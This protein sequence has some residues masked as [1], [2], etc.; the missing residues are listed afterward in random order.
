[1]SIEPLTT[2]LIGRDAL[3]GRLTNL[4]QRAVHGDRTAT[5]LAGPAG[6]GKTSLLRAVA[7]D[8]ARQGMI[9]GWG[10]CVASGAPG[11][12]P[13]SQALNE[14]I[15]ELGVDPARALAG[16]EESLIASVATTLAATRREPDRDTGDARSARLQLMDAVSRWLGALAEERPVM[17]IM[18]DLQWA[19]GSTV[20]LLDFVAAAPGRAAVALLGAYRDDELTSEGRKRLSTLVAH[21]EHLR[22]PGL[23]PTSIEALVERTAG[24]SVPA[25]VSLAIS[26]RSAGHPLFARELATSWLS[27]ADT[28]AVPLA[29]RGLIERR[30]HGLRE[31]TADVLAV[32][33]VAGRDVASEL[34]A[35]ATDRT[36]VDV[37]LAARE[38]AD[39]GILTPDGSG[40]LRFAHDLYRET[41][42]E[43]LLPFRRQAIHSALGRVLEQRSAA[44]EPAEIARH[45]VASM[46]VDG[47]ERAVRW[48]LVAASADIDALAFTEA[49]DRLH[50][51]RS[52][53]A[54]LGLAVPPDQLVRL[55]LTEADALARAGRAP[56]ARP[57]LRL[58]RASV[59]TSG[60]AVRLA[61]VALAASQLGSQFSA[62]RDE[63]VDDLES[64]LGRPDVLP[65]AIRARLMATL[66][67]ELQHSVSA[68]RERAA[69]LSERALEIGRESGDPSAMLSCL[70]ARHDVLWT[71]GKAGERADLAREIGTVA[72]RARDAESQ[73]TGL[74]LLANAELERGSGAYLTALESCLQLLERLG[75]PRHHYT[76]VTRRA[77]LA[78]LRGDL[79]EAARGITAGEQLG[80]RIHE[81]DTGNVAMSQ[82]LELVRARRIPAQLQDFATE[83]L[84]HWVGAPVHANAVAAG[85]YARSG[86]LERAAQHTSTVLDLGS[87]QADRSYLWSV[88]VRE[89]SRAAIALGD[90]DLCRRL[91]SDLEPLAGQCG[92]NGAVVAFAGSHA[93]TA[94]LLART[95]GDLEATE[96]HLDQARL[97]YRRLGARSWLA[98]LERDAG[99]SQRP[100]QTDGRLRR[101]GSLWDIGFAGREAMVAGTKGLEDIARLVARPGVDI[102]ALELMTGTDTHR[103][104]SSAMILDRAALRSYR[105]RLAE[106]DAELDD[107]EQAHDAATVARLGGEREA[108]VDEL[109]AATTERG[110]PR[111]FA[112]YPSERARKAVSGRVRAAIAGLRPGL[113]ELAEHL[114]SS[115][116]TGTYCRYRPTDVTWHVSRD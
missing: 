52:A 24:D 70:L 97:T 11:F 67:R 50:R 41:V 43:A 81:P 88:L 66:A 87:W 55:I 30:L 19:D 35:S 20:E 36:A 116:I 34:V 1:M 21:S 56:E 71:P 107:A 23:D 25:E 114:D 27:T 48:S 90:L 6:I 72:H 108:L 57:L 104:A 31:A 85:F 78:L 86:D 80:S 45:F 38:A 99:A 101:V 28:S 15:T 10:T 109:R 16:D 82:R 92:V 9:V 49:A 4:T 94:G 106:L 53:A 18:D 73:A 42:V 13:C 29:V 98:D 32:A 44:Q 8:A 65:P 62:R 47:T 76:A 2:E 14:V 37:E 60:D 96:R 103:S 75:Q 39:V 110:R 95:L 3:L 115:I 105:G 79:D 84:R 93:H 33:A 22:V 74:L 113:P 61:E 51:V 100:N 91:L 12:W 111:V 69:A 7:S 63:V 64:S 54:D 112:N 40:Q 46:P 83:A 89:L 5:L 26:R 102:H 77:A 17:I 59:T 68:D 58:A